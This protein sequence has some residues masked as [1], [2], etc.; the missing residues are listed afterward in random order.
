MEYARI[1]EVRMKKIFIL[2]LVIILLC[3]VVMHS[4]VTVEIHHIL[5]CNDPTCRACMQLQLAQKISEIFN[6]FIFKYFAIFNFLAMLFYS[7]IKLIYPMC[8]GLVD[9]KVRLNE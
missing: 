6:H 2:T 4:F 5:K 3:V 9:L 1:V 7:T 8:N